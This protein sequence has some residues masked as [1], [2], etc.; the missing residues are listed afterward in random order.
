MTGSRARALRDR[1]QSRADHAIPFPDSLTPAERRTVEAVMQHG[2]D[3]VAARAMGISPSTLRC[4]KQ[5]A[6]VKAGV[7]STVRLVVVYLAAKGQA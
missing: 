2:E 6:K 3:K 1:M 5:M 7:T 4:H